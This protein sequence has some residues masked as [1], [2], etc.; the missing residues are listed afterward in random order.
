MRVSQNAAFT[1][2]PLTDEL[3]RE[4]FELSPTQK[5][6]MRQSLILQLFSE[7]D[8]QE[9]DGKLDADEV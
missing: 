4:I 3:P 1:R 2:E 9:D 8:H 7:Q 6:T 5:D